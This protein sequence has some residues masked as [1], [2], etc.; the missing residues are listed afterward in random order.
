MPISSTSI[1]RVR[2]VS[3]ERLGLASR[4]IQREHQLP[5]QALAQRMLGDERLELAHELAMAAIREVR[6]NRV[7]ERAQPQLLQPPDRRRGE[8][9]VGDVGQRRPVPERERLASGAI[10]DE[11]LEAAHV[12]V[13]RRDAQLVAAPAREDLGGVPVTGSVEQLA[14]PRNVLLEHLRRAR[15][16]LLAPQ[17]LD[18]LVGR[19]GPVRV[20]R[21]HGQQRALLGGAESDGSPLDA[22]PN[23]AE[24]ADG[25]EALYDRTPARATDQGASYRH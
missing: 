21:E 19:H 16:R 5:A 24:E 9:L 11:P 23:G 3:L 22:G 13:V 12:E 15:R 7:L 1:S 18:Q 17:R 25:H 2:A 6:I 20:Q 14:Q 8:R 10:R 4:P